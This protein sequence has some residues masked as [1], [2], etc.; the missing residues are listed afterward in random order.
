MEGD[1]NVTAGEV[2]FKDQKLQGYIV[3]I[4]NVKHENVKSDKMLQLTTIHVHESKS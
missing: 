3:K 2:I 4:E 1:F